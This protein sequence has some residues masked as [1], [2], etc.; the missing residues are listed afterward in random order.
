LDLKRRFLKEFTAI[1]PAGHLTR[2]DDHGTLMPV[3]QSKSNGLSV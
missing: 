1:L 2:K 3:V